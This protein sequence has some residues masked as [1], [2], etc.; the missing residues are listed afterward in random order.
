MVMRVPSLP[1]ETMTF[2]DELQKIIAENND[3][4]RISNRN[5]AARSFNSLR[6]H[7]LPVGLEPALPT[8]PFE[9]PCLTT[10]N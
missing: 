1:H 4:Q 6:L 5:L 3:K 2:S 7:I 10:M 8:L 9:R